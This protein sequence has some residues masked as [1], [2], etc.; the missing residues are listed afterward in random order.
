MEA[1]SERAGGTMS[2]TEIQELRA[3]FRG[4]LITSSDAG[5]DAARKVYNGMIDRRPA[6]IARC[7]DVA[8]AN[9]AEV[10]VG[11]DPEPANNP[12]LMQWAKDY[13]LALHPF[14]SG[15]GYINMMMDEGEDNVKNAYRDNYPRLAKVKRTYDPNNLFRVNQNIKPA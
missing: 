13:W 4:E 3:L 15:G 5:Y 12:R 9:F 10:I 7:A 1:L 14:S 11:V 8:E 6:L 2:Q